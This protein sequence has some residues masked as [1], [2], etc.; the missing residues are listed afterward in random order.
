MSEVADDAIHPD[1]IQLFS[2]AHD[3]DRH[4]LERFGRGRVVRAGA[5]RPGTHQSIGW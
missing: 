3:R 1:E 5:L 2:E 4:A